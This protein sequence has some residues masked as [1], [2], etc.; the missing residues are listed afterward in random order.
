[1]T[2]SLQAQIGLCARAQ[3]VL[4]GAMIAM[5][6]GFYLFEYRP[7]MQ[8]RAELR[9]QIDAKRNELLASKTL[10]EGNADLALSVEKLKYQLGPF[11]M[12]MPKQ[13]DLGQFFR[14]VTEIS[15]STRLR[16]WDITHG[17]PSRSNLFGELPIKLKF[18]GE[19]LNVVSFL[20]QVEDMKRLTRVRDINIKTMNAKLGHVEVE[21]TM[22]IYFAEG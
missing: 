21:L 5:V 3:W 17:S 14:E 4:A 6:G 7:A 16:G 22:N 19:F 18:T 13:A 2:R 10:T 12:K 8:K 11:D 15:Q 1:M 9:M 20:R